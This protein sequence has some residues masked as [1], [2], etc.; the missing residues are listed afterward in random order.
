MRILPR[1]F[2]L[3]GVTLRYVDKNSVVTATQFCTYWLLESDLEHKLIERINSATVVGYP[4]SEAVRP[5]IET[6]T[7]LRTKWRWR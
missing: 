6:V 4:F 2:V 5:V 1:K 3:L 7:V